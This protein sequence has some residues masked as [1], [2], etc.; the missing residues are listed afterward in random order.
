M[1][2]HPCPYVCFPVTQKPTEIE[3][4]P[5]AW[6]PLQVYLPPLKCCIMCWPQCCRNLSITVPLLAV[7]SLSALCPKGP[8]W[9]RSRQFQPVNAFKWI[10]RHRCVLAERFQDVFLLLSTGQT[11]CDMEGNGFKVTYWWQTIAQMKACLCLTVPE[12]TL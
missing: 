10:S 8:C 2:V 1:P 6:H 4:K 3:P 5:A 7:C 11:S 12:H 9:F